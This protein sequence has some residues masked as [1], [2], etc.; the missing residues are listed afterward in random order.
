[1]KLQMLKMRTEILTPFLW[2]DRH[3][4]ETMLYNIQMNTVIPYT[5]VKH[6]FISL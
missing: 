3:A 4:D 2:N 6:F 5:V 1:M